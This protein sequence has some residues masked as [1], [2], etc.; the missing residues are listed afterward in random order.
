MTVTPTHDP[1]TEAIALYLM[2][3]LNTRWQG[4]VSQVSWYDNLPQDP[5]AFPHLVVHR[6]DS[7][8]EAL[9][10]C[11]G[12]VRYLSAGQEKKAFRALE[13][14]IV[15]LLR[16]YDDPTFTLQIQTPQK[17]VCKEWLMFFEIEFQ[18]IDF[19]TL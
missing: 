10:V 6:R 9:E 15:E 11:R 17:F 2:E 8:G 12:V 7:Q 1:A 18:F 13:L 3:G 5:A 4:S 16:K 14:A 19:A